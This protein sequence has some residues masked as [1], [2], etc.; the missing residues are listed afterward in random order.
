MNFKK[1]NPDKSI[2]LF[3]KSILVFEENETDL[4]TALPFFADGYPG[5]VFHETENGLVIKP[6]NKQMPL[7]FY[8]VKP[9]NPLNYS[10]KVLTNSSFFN[11]IILF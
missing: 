4:K 6:Y 9:F 10:F 11:S 2:A 1:I 8:M 3:V 5:I 7:F